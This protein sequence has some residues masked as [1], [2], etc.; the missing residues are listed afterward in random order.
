MTPPRTRHLFA[1]LLLATFGVINLAIFKS[2]PISLNLAGLIYAWLLEVGAFALAY[3]M[4]EHILCLILGE[5]HLPSLPRLDRHPAVA[6]ICVTCDD[7][8]VGVLRLLGRQGYPSL[9][10]FILD[11]SEKRE[12]RDSIDKLGFKVVRREGRNGYK[13][14][15]LNNWLF[16]HGS[17]YD[18]FIVADADSIFPI[19]FVDRMIRVAECPENHKIAIIESTIYPWNKQHPFVKP[20]AVLAPFQK[21]RQLRLLNRLDSTLSVGHNNLYR[22]SVLLSIGGFSEQYIAEDYAT[23]IAVLQR[24]S[25]KCRTAT[26]ESFERAPAN[27]TEYARRQSRW[28][29]Q[30]FQLCSLTT[31]RLP[32][33]TRLA[34]VHSLLYFSMPVVTYAAM[35]WLVGVNVNFWMSSVP[36][37]SQVALIAS[38]VGHPAFMLWVSWLIGPAALRL[39]LL[40]R[41]GASVRAYIRGTLFQ[42]ALFFATTW[43]VI[44]RITSFRQPDRQRFTVTGM[45]EDPH[46]WDIFKLGAPG[47]LLAWC[48][49]LSFIPVP[50]YL[51]LNLVWLIP[52]CLSPF[53]VHRVEDSSDDA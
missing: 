17:V 13:A 43:P 9:D 23:T 14:G 53:I 35:L 22:T 50:H 45:S 30:T 51:A 40:Y 20:Q 16:K 25:W 44:R 3:D 38:F 52:A 12:S 46:L 29:A 4:S 6:L 33:E 7:V 26:I 42:A 27:I 37:Q 5:Y 15:N 41:E 21:V 32:W 2:T 10:V 24:T 11:D 18:Y 1:V 47:V 34:L 48:T 36:G 39:A 49:L 8:D 19:D 28:A 31:T